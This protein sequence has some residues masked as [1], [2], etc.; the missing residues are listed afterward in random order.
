MRISRRR[1]LAGLS[2]APLLGA[3]ARLQAQSAFPSRPLTLV[4]PF[5]AGGPS[6]VFG[7]HL[8]QGLGPRSRAPGLARAARPL[9]LKA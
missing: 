8:A 7:R 6:D 5:P 4:I 1:A 9:R 3:G 2:A